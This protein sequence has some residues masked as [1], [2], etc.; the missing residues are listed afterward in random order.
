MTERLPPFGDE[1]L[2][3][4]LE[5][6]KELAFLHVPKTGGTYVAHKLLG[7]P[8]E[9]PRPDEQTQE[10]KDAHIDHYFKNMT[11]YVPPKAAPVPQKFVHYL[12]D[13]YE[14][15]N[16]KIHL[17]KHYFGILGTPKGLPV[18]AAVRNPFDWLVS[19]YASNFRG[20]LSD[21]HR[22]PP[23]RAVTLEEFIE[24][25][26][27]S[28]R[29]SQK[30]FLTTKQ[31]WFG[32]HRTGAER[33]MTAPPWGGD[34]GTRTFATA[35]G[36]VCAVGRWG[37]DRGTRTFATDKDCLSLSPLYQ[38][39]Q[40]R[41]TPQVAFVLRQEFLDDALR[42]MLYYLTRCDENYKYVRDSRVNVSKRGDVYIQRMPRGD[43]PAG[44]DYRELFSDS[45]RKMVEQYYGWELDLL[46]YDFEKGV[47]DDNPIL[48]FRN[49]KWPSTAKEST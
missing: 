29:L 14:K 6:A 42:K 10:W 25:F 33:S 46:G 19:L 47:L 15:H 38:L 17:L 5:N 45:A 23:D 41:D 37:G 28:G 20:F 7:A 9:I 40:E 43:G 31:H 11:G 16:I 26:I 27:K 24:A 22:D 1:E 48:D 36:V 4:L 2:K 32:G 34:R 12:E 49:A 30:R 35:G 3:E 13:Q 39:F 18:F 44:E 21:V 8:N